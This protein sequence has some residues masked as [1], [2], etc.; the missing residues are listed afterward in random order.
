MPPE[1][2]QHEEQEQQKSN[3]K[4]SFSD[5][6]QEFI[7]K[8]LAEQKRS[9]R[10]ENKILSQKYTETAE[11]VQSLKQLLAAA[12]KDAGM[13]MSANGFEDEEDESSNGNNEFSQI[14]HELTPP[15]GVPKEAWMQIQGIKHGYGKQIEMLTQQQREQQELIK[16][17]S[18][19]AKKE[20]ALREQTERQATIAERNSI[21]ADALNRANCIDIKAGTRLFADNVIRHNGR[22][23][24]KPDGAR[25]EEDYLPLEKGLAKEIPAYMIKASGTSGG[26][27]SNGSAPSIAAKRTE[28]EENVRLW[29]EKASGSRNERDIAM[30]QKSKREL[31]EFNRTNPTG[32]A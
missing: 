28:L 13:R 9:I 15:K 11:E 14:L 8:L 30:Y 17:L 25:D 2:E 29:A 31:A 3:E 16:E 5:E 26:A 22:W 21:L 24:Y 19:I 27:G 20:Q 32:A 10:E 4:V 1:A 6:Q 7:N 18:E 12:A 23:M